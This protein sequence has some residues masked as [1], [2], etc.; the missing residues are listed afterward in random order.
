M[1]HLHQSYA[2]SV[3]SSSD[4]RPNLALVAASTAAQN[5]TKYTKREV[6]E[7]V[8]AKRFWGHIGVTSSGD[9][10]DMI[11]H[12]MIEDCPSSTHDIYS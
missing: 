6:E 5:M 9:A 7:A 11:C 1:R 10:F 4:F 8:F 3:A 2:C 12:G